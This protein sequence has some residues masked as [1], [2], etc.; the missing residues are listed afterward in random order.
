MGI[1]FNCT[2]YR[3]A[4]LIDHIINLNIFHIDAKN[5]VLKKISPCQTLTNLSITNFLQ[6]HFLPIYTQFRIVDRLTIGTV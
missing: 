5:A 2:S 6:L 3:W 1:D 4:I